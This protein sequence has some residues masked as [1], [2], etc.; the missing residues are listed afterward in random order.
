MKE[1]IVNNLSLLTDHELF[2]AYLNALADDDKKQLNKIQKEI[3][4]RNNKD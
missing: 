4:K 2:V 1:N 3:N